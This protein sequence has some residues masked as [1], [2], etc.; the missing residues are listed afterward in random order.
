MHYKQLYLPDHFIYGG[1]WNADL[2]RFHSQHTIA[3]SQFCVEE[4]L[5]HVYSI[6][7]SVDYTYLTDINCSKSLI[8]HFF[9]IINN[10]KL[11]VIN[12]IKKQSDHLPLCMSITLPVCDT[13]S[14]STRQ[15]V[16]KPKWFM[17]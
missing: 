9:I 5:I 6:N 17:G 1:D 2:S 8:D 10:N 7:K 14:N 12:D 11:C 15:F 3:L 4:H 16:P 13:E